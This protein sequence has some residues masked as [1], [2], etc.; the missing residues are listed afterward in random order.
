[1][2]AAKDRGQQ[3][4][5]H[6][7]QNTFKILINSFYGYLGFAQGHFA[8]FDAAALLVTQ[9]Q[10][11]RAIPV[12]EGFRRNYPQSPLQ[13]DVTRNLAVA[14]SESNKPGQ[15]AVEFEQIAQSPKETPEVQREATLQSADL[16][17]KAGNTAKSRTMLDSTGEWLK[18]L[19]PDDPENTILK[20]F[21]KNKPDDEQTDEP[22]APATGDGYS[23]P[24]R[25]S[26]KKLI[27]KPAAR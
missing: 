15:A 7:L 1:M 14:Y 13:A 5:F 20:R 24:A 2:R 23:K 21:K 25:D 16:Y 12:L 6:A 17:G 27:E 19:L 11:D 8:D 10:W 22:A 4:Y 26:L 9:K 3:Q 18:G